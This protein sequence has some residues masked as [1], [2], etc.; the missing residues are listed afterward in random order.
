METPN[1]PHT[2]RVPWEKIK[3]E[4]TTQA[5][6]NPGID[7]VGMPNEPEMTST[8]PH[9]LSNEELL[10]QLMAQ[11]GGTT[12]ELPHLRPKHGAAGGH[13]NSTA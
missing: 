7:Q 12:L 3:D 9:L 6:K 4:D 1:Q 5:A 10:Q 13:C 11:F 2:L 8:K